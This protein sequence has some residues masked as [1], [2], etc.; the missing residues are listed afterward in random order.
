LP[1][2][3][4]RLYAITDRKRCAPRPLLEVVGELLEAGVRGFQIREKDLDPG[5]LARLAGPIVRLCR[6]YRARVLVNSHIRVALE[7]GADGIHLPASA[8]MH[9]EHRELLIGRS[10]HSPEERDERA[11]F[12]VYGP[13]FPTNSKPGGPAKGVEGLRQA[14]Q[15]SPV[16]VFALGGIT[17]P[18]V[19]DC[20]RAGAFGVAV[21][22]GLMRPE[23]AGVWARAY[24]EELAP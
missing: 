16:P 7:T 10:I 14:A 12:V 15:T 17:P 24:L 9:D 19:G 1:S 21:L 18:R 23:G 13:V 4:F 22:S 3:E 5:E 2:P 8:Q 11:D 20:L 6:Q